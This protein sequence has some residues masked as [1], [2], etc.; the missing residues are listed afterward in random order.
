MYPLLVKSIEFHFN[1]DFKIVKIDKFKLPTLGKE[2]S[3]EKNGGPII[4]ILFKL[5]SI[6]FFNLPSSEELRSIIDKPQPFYN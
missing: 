2:Y 3:V 4:E 5:D 1:C 6:H